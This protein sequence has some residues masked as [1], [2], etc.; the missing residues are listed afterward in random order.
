MSALHELRSLLRLR[1]LQLLALSSL[2]ILMAAIAFG[3]ET[4]VRDPDLWWHLKVGDWVVQ[5]HAVPYVG[6]FSRTAANRPWI[7][8]S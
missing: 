1:A 6:I 4:T 8:Y 5:H 2:L 3:S 7:A